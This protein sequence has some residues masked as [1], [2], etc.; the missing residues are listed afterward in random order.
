MRTSILRHAGLCRVALSLSA[1]RVQP[2]FRV[3]ASV[4]STSHSIQIDRS[5]Y[6]PATQLS[7]FY[8]AEASAAHEP[9]SSDITKFRDMESLGVHPKIIQSVVDGMKYELMTP[10]QSMTIKPGLLGKDLVAQAKTGTGK[11]LGFLIPILQR[12]IE[13]D[14]SVAERANSRP[15]SDDVRAIIISPTRELAEQIGEEAR[16]LVRGTG[17]AV[18]TAVG[19]TMKRL[20][21]AK[22]RREGCHLLVGTPGRLND[23]LSDEHSGVAAPNLGA[24]ALDEADRMLEVG[25]MDELR[26]ILKSL[27]DRRDVSRQTLLF[28]ATIPK[29]V[30]GLARDF[31]DPTNF[32][33]VQTI[34]EDE[35]P[36]HEKVP[37][38]I[39]P[40]KGFINVFPALLEL[41]EREVANL[42][43]NPDAPPFKAMVFLP[44]TASVRM[45]S[46]LFRRLAYQNRDLP[47]VS[48]IHSKLTQGQRTQAADN[49][50]RARSAILFT[51][52]VTARGMDFP[53]V[54]HVIQCHTPPNREQ[55]I[56]RLGRTG[57]AGKAGQGWLFVIDPELRNARHTLTDLPIKRSTDL[58]CASVDVS[59]GQDLPSQFEEVS[60]GM[61]RLPY[62]IFDDTYG[63]FLGSLF[64]SCNMQDIVDSLNEAATQQWG[65]K[66]TPGLSHGRMRNMPRGISGIRT[67]DHSAHRSSGRGDYGDRGGF[68][69][70]GGDRGGRDNRDPF[71]TLGGGSDRSSGGGRG[72]G[73]GDRRGGG[74]GGGF[75]G[76][77][78]SSF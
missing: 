6:G 44:T 39:V 65:L 78:R 23:L 37:Q 53:N 52:D 59:S 70:R 10:V 64:A 47:D 49:F 3:V 51:S 62:E 60:R 7:R 56:H 76:R 68:G 1:R 77:A 36:T 35:T 71:S 20:A 2:A 32:Q 29:N 25:F 12:I 8:S 43:A 14:P 4:A 40:C 72:Y 17:I 58:T 38:Y 28:S 75:G 19:G 26:E 74:G 24:L 55:Y 57:R 63:T 48:D 9:A 50:R 30:V 69:G 54:T 27:P 46:A 18:Q 41:I 67:A 42:K 45:A 31:I 5:R 66:E 13:R 16:K 22:L 61:Q 33:F 34:R 21:L 11:T 15:R 73:G